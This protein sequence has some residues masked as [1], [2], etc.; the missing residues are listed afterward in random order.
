MDLGKIVKDGTYV[1]EFIRLLN[2]CFGIREEDTKFEI[3]NLFT[4]DESVILGAIDQ[5]MLQGAVVI[6]DFNI[7]W[8]GITVKMGGIGGV[9]TFPEAREKHAVAKLIS[10]SLK[11]M[12]DN[13]QVFSLLAPFSYSFY[14][15][16]GWEWGMTRNFLTINI[17]NLS[18]F[19]NED[20]TVKSIS[21]ESI[22]EI[23]EVYEGYYGQ[24][25][26]P[27]KRT[28]LRW[29]LLFETNKR[30]NVYSYG[31]YDTKK[32]LC[33]Y[34]F[35]KL[36][37]NQMTISEMGYTS[38]K[39]HK[40]LLRF[41]YVHR[42]QAEKVVMAVPDNDPTI[43]LLN[44]QRQ[45]IK[46]VSTLM[47]RV[48]D[49]KKVLERYPYTETLDIDIRIRIEDEYAPWNNKVFSLSKRERKVKVSEG[50]IDSYDI[51][52]PIQVFSQIAF[53]FLSFKEADQLELLTCENK[54]LLGK[55]NQLM[56][57]KTTYMTDSF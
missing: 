35:Y 28:H 6:N 8:H 44:N 4:K 24:Y 7:F 10:E 51:K 20:H 12:Y 36:E 2:Y 53:G 55:L 42:A 38:L 15:R 41:I 18:H 40:Q 47:V 34:I 16:Y 21:I 54:G 52:C 33:G 30:N 27:S 26:G 39:A 37:D 19:K 22:E 5:N 1:D 13:N 49:V 48:V 43:L 31:V 3:D 29:E 23:K 46:K 32:K 57:V 11:T 14:R 17:S 25:N 50:P 9:A 56:V 45:E